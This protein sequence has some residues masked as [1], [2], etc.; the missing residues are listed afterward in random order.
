MGLC[1]TNKIKKTDQ[2]INPKELPRISSLIR[3]NRG[4]LPES[5]TLCR[6]PFHVVNKSLPEEGYEFS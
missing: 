1:K 4:A 5:L 6:I 3:N 2:L